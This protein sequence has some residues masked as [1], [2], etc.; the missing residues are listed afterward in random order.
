MNE[1]LA[2]VRQTFPLHGYHITYKL[3]LMIP[4]KSFCR[5]FP[6]STAKPKNFYLFLFIDIFNLG[7][8]K[9]ISDMSYFF[10]NIF[11]KIDF[12]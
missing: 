6:Q 12:Q 10:E 7:A 5:G 11:K 8:P 2:Y 3:F 9:T 1:S 4:F